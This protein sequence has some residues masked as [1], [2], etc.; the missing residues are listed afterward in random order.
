MANEDIQSMKDYMASRL[1]T[2]E[3][4]VDGEGH[5]PTPSAHDDETVKSQLSLRDRL[6]ELVLIMTA[7][8]EA[9][10]KTLD[11]LD[12]P[13]PESG[14][15]FRSDNEGSSGVAQNAQRPEVGTET[16]DQDEGVGDP[17]ISSAEDA[18][19]EGAPA[20]SEEEGRHQ[21]FVKKYGSHLPGKDQ[22]KEAFI[23]EELS[24]GGPAG[25][26]TIEQW[27]KE[28]APY[29]IKQGAFNEAVIHGW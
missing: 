5:E 28:S 14:E 7:T 6:R 8:Q 16:S 12:G 24:K 13:Q 2:V 29:L 15:P 3:D 20:E 27:L 1:E 9:V 22:T 10:S 17:E 4:V 25:K 11:E 26:A 21:K 23:A 18:A 19:E